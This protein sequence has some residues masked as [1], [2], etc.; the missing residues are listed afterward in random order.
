[1]KNWPK[2]NYTWPNLPTHSYVPDTPVF[3]TSFFSA[4]NDKNFKTKSAPASKFL[5]KTWG[6]RKTRNSRIFWISTKK[7]FESWQK[8]TTTTMMK[9]I[10]RK[11][12]FKAKKKTISFFNYFLPKSLS[13]RTSYLSF[14]L[15]PSST[16]L[17]GSPAAPWPAPAPTLATASASCPKSWSTRPLQEQHRHSTNSIWT[18][19]FFKPCYSLP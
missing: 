18:N 8:T 7:I 2:I 14:Q 9:M 15:S 3:N 5:N 10:R 17:W 19:V 12:T 4:L 1:M 13:Y 11:E 6:N 16:R